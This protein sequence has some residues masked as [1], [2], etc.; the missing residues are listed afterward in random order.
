MDSYRAVLRFKGLV[1]ALALL[2]GTG[3]RGA[4][5]NTGVEDILW[6]AILIGRPIVLVHDLVFGSDETAMKAADKAAERILN[7]HAGVVTMHGLY[8]GAL[9]LRWALFGLFVERQL[10]LVEMDV[11]GSAWL[12]SMMK[13]PGRLVEDAKDHKYIRLALKEKGDPHCVDWNFRTVE[14]VESP[15]VRPPACLTVSFADRLS[16]DVEMSVD[17]SRASHRELRWQLKDRVRNTVLL[18]VPFWHRQTRGNPLYV[19]LTYR[20]A[21]ENNPFIRVL[22][23]LSPAEPAT[24]SEGRPFLM[25]RF[26]E[27]RRSDDLDLPSFRVWGYFR[28]RTVAVP[29]TRTRGSEHWWTEMYRS[30]IADGR[31]AVYGGLM[32]NPSEDRVGSSCAFVYRRCEAGSEV[33]VGTEVGVLSLAHQRAYGPPPQEVARL[34][35]GHDAWVSVGAK[36][37]SGRFL[38]SMTVMLA[39]WPAPFEVCK[40]FSLGCDFYPKHA[41][42]T[43][44]GLLISGGAVGRPGIG[45]GYPWEL[46]VPAQYLPAGVSPFGVETTLSTTAPAPEAS[47]ADRSNQ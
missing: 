47:A 44:E 15:P 3:S 10:P 2:S 38:W 33:S 24:N 23:K 22:K 21:H 32:I 43:P 12:F 9:D 31:P 36:D 11:S 29:P 45:G 4:G 37:Y 27:A 18:D 41:V 34:G 46:W 40:D 5:I 42:F 16:S 19:D 25:K 14:W 7:D 26:D 1:V 8:T 28:E 17:F 6:P 20:Q 30:A 35:P 39:A 13:T